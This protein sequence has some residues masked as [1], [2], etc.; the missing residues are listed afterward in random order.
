MKIDEITAYCNYIHFAIMME[1]KEESDEAATANIR[2]LQYFIER[3]DHA[4]PK[5][6]SAISITQ[7]A[8]EYLNDDDFTIL[9]DEEN[10]FS[11]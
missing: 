4:K 9:I 1:G 10:V 11:N 6:P 5:L 3:T 2:K 8:R 7:L